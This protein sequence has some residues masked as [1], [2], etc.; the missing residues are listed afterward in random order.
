MKASLRRLR[1]ARGLSQDGLARAAG[2]PLGTLRNVEQGLSVPRIDT[3][4]KLARALGGDR[5]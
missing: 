4:A 5:R 3:A 1:L 2:V